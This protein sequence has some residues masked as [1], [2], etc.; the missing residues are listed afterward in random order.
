[1]QGI[2]FIL[3]DT[4]KQTQRRARIHCYQEWCAWF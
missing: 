2:I 3:N 1:L 4:L